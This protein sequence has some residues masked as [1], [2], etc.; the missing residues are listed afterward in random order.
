MHGAMMTIKFISICG[1]FA[2]GNNSDEN[3]PRPKMG[4][5]FAVLR[6]WEQGFEK[7]QVLLQ[8]ALSCANPRKLSHFA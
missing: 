1:N 4:Q 2:I 3:F 6:V 7:L 5:I 8:K